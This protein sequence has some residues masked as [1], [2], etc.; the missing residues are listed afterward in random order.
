MKMPK[1]RIVASEAAAKD[2]FLL[3]SSEYFEKCVHDLMRWRLE[4]MM[5]GYRIMQEFGAPLA[6]APSMTC[7]D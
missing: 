3:T 5:L 7:G 6:A 4:E 2:G 1:V